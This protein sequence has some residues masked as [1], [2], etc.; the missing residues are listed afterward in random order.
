MFRFYSNKEGQAIKSIRYN[1]LKPSRNMFGNK[2]RTPVYWSAHQMMCPIAL[3]FGAICGMHNA[4][5]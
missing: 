2:S 3:R 1:S 4:W 5:F